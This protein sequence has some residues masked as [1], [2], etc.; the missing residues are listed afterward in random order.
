MRH[1][2]TMIVIVAASICCVEAFWQHRETV[3]VEQ[4]SAKI[5]ADANARTPREKTLAIRD[6][7]RANVT[8]IGAPMGD[9]RPFLRATAAET[10][11][12]GLGF[13]GEVSRAFINLAQPAGIPAA[14]LNLFSKEPHV[15]A[16]VNLG[17]GDDVIVDSLRVPSVADLETIDSLMS[18]HVYDDYSTLN[19][20][21]LQLGFLF[22]RTKMTLGPLTYWGENPHAMKATAWGL[23]AATLLALRGL[24]H[25]VRR[26]L[27]WRGWVHRSALP[28]GGE[29][30]PPP[31]EPTGDASSDSARGVVVA[32]TP[33]E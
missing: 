6:Y 1:L 10:L 31:S 8:H 2:R 27:H 25:G 14:R 12:S 17:A 22:K 20:R 13:C 9:D 30:E 23:I 26:F 32:Q 21:R 15:V 18:R 28:G 19:L 24:R 3:F 7:L 29:P 11:Q 33:G 4:L 16:Y 5:V